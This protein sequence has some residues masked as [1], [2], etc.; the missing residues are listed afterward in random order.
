M[1]PNAHAVLAVLEVDFAF[2]HAHLARR[3]FRQTERDLHRLTRLRVNDECLVRPRA[4]LNV[5][6]NSGSVGMTGATSHGLGAGNTPGGGPIGNGSLGSGCGGGST[7]KPGG[8]SGTG[9][10]CTPAMRPTCTSTPGAQRG[11]SR[12]KTNVPTGV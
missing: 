3:A 5:A 11:A 1:E 6:A 9:R 4:C 8:A 7:G 2:R 12:P 10:T